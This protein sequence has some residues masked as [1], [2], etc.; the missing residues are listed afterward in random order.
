MTK[1]RLK[2]ANPVTQA[3]SIVS[4]S[5]ASPPLVD[6]LRGWFESEWGEIDPFEGNHDD[7]Q[8]PRPILALD[9]Q[10][11]LAGGLAFSSANQPGSEDIAVWI[12][13]LLVAP[14]HRRT[15]LA[16]RLVQEAHDRAAELGV[17]RL[18]VR[19]D[20][21]ALYEKLAWQL[22][23]RSGPDSILTKDLAV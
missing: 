18:F 13:A 9:A 17:Q 11:R 2:I 7:V 23:E 16:S 3:F 15:G 6:Q 14:E 4:G 12:N 20:V 21:P 8:V 5:S 22:V 10:R 19:S 1:G